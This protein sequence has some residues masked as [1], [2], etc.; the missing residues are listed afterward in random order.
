MIKNIHT[1]NFEEVKLQLSEVEKKLTQANQDEK[2]EE[3]RKRKGLYWWFLFPIF[4]WIIF[5]MILTRRGQT[6][7]YQG[8]LNNIKMNILELELDKILL[9]KRL[10]EL[11]GQE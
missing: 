10:G 6:E 8:K 9:K 5:G 4:G 7:Y 1:L 11:N 3:Q 2:K